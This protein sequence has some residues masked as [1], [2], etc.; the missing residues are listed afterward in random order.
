METSPRFATECTPVRRPLGDAKWDL[1]HPLRIK[2]A[3]PCSPLKFK[4]PYRGA[5]FTLTQ[6]RFHLNAMHTSL[7]TPG[8]AAAPVYV[9]ACVLHF[10]GFRR[11]ICW[12]HLLVA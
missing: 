9:N 8:T 10:G 7:Q 12:H 2:R 3:P 5:F 6:L 11:V 1:N 4:R